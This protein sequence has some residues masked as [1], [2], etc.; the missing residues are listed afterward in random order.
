MAARLSRTPND[1]CPI[2]LEA[3]EELGATGGGEEGTDGVKG[4]AVARNE[5]VQLAGAPQVRVLKCLH[6]I[7][8]Q[9]YLQMKTAACPLCMV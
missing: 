3:F 2:C 4:T 9:C 1:T 6:W 5:E 7:H 8:A